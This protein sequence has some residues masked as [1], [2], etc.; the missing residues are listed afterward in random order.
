[1]NK[2][3]S[4]CDKPATS[5][6]ELENPNED[7][8]EHY[9]CDEH[10]SNFDDYEGE[11]NELE[12]DPKS[13]WDLLEE[14]PGGCDAVASLYQW[15]TNYDCGKGPFTLFIDLIG[16]SEDN[17]GNTIYDYRSL[18]RKLGFVELSKLADALTAYADRSHDVS[19]YV[20]ALLE[21]EAR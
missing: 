14:A 7:I 6:Q 3:C 21:A 1:M 19:D 16:W 9:A 20:S 17:I 4:W 15:S 18:Q 12:T 8:F 13:V 2:Q 10:V 5:K 11:V